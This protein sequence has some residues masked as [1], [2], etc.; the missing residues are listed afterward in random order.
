MDFMEEQ[1]RRA[2]LSFDCEKS[3]GVILSL[4][5]DL[6]VLQQLMIQGQFKEGLYMAE[7][8][9]W[10]SIIACDI[11]ELP[12]VGLKTVQGM[13]LNEIARLD[14]TFWHNAKQGIYNVA[15]DGNCS[16]IINVC[17]QAIDQLRAATR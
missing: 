11:D 16:S 1:R 10:N 17:K 14:S 7:R 3:V 8:C 13:I 12:T 9:C 6:E 2:L 4:I 5:Q 15:A